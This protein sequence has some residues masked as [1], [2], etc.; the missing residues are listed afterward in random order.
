MFGCTARPGET[1]DRRLTVHL[2]SKR[3][4]C[5][6]GS[7]GYGLAGKSD[8]LTINL[9]GGGMSLLCLTGRQVVAFIGNSDNSV[10]ILTE[11]TAHF[12]S[13][14]SLVDEKSILKGGL[15]VI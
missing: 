15:E 2:V 1:A 6:V 9:E 7:D 5:D 13:I 12:C 4:T 8:R 14:A 11:R 3:R 10:A